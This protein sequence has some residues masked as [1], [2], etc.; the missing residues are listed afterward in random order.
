MTC[1]YVFRNDPRYVN[2]W[3]D[4][5]QN[6]NLA[7]ENFAYMRKHGI[8]VS[9][10]SFYIA[11]AEE[12]EKNGDFENA[13]TLYDLG[14]QLCAQPYETIHQMKMYLIFVIFRFVKF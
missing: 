14:I 3:L 4:K 9:C 1:C 5:A 6:S 12:Y 10:A 7:E 2:A 13:K 11:W 8:G